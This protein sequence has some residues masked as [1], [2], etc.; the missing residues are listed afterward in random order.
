[1]RHDVLIAGAGPAGC[2]TAVVLARAGARVLVLDRARFPRD[3]LCGDTLNPGALAV[4]RRLGLDVADAGLPLRGMLITGPGGAQVRAAYPDGV[5]G[6]ALVR[7][8]LDRALLHR[9]VEAGAAVDEGVLVEA[10]LIETP[11]CAVTGVVVRANGAVRR[12]HA[13]IVIGADGRASR[14]ARAVALAKHPHRPRRWALGAYFTDVAG[15][16]GFGEMHVRCGFYIGVAP[17]PDGL[18]NACV[19]TADRRKL[20]QPATLLAQT[21]RNDP[22]LADRF[23]AARMVTR[24]VSLG[25]MA[26]ECAAPGLPGLL[27]AG[28]AAG[29]VDPMTGDGLRFALRGG[30][31][32]A[33]EALRVLETGDPRAHERLAAARR[34]EFSTKVRFD[35]LL[36]RLAGSPGAVRLASLASRLSSWPVERMVRYAGDL[37]A[38]GLNGNFDPNLE[39][40]P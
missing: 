17:L 5:T 38:T 13:R 30:E 23:A 11:A 36:R 29:F 20:Q 12:V 25:P 28:D 2:L 34:R 6:R 8:D 31:L 27:L 26:V 1:M 37:G 35:R 39:P 16:T 4:L 7:R 32:A 40:E 9:A 18:T 14:L 10:P 19:V 24:P 22:L 3:K 21:L 15:M 33:Q